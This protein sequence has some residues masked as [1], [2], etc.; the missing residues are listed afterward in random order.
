[1]PRSSLP[2]DFSPAEHLRKRQ[3]LERVDQVSFSKSDLNRLV[4]DYLVT[5]GY[6]SAAANLALEAEI[7][8]DAIDGWSFPGSVDTVRA[9][10]DIRNALLMGQVGKAISIINDVDSM[11]LDKC[12]SLHFAVLQLQFIELIRPLSSPTSDISAALRFATHNLAPLAPTNS[13]FLSQLEQTMCLLIFPRDKL[14]PDLLKLLD[15]SLRETVAKRVNRALLLSPALDDVD[16]QDQ[17]EDGSVDG[18]DETWRQFCK[19]TSLVKLRH[20]VEKELRRSQATGR[21]AQESP[22]TGASS[23][24]NGITASARHNG[25]SN[26]TTRTGTGSTNNDTRPNVAATGDSSMP[27][28]R[29]SQHHDDYIIPREDE[30][31]YWP[32]GNGSSYLEGRL[33]TGDSLNALLGELLGDNIAFNNNGTPNSASV[34]DGAI[35]AV[36]TSTDLS[37]EQRGQTFQQQQ[38]SQQLL[39]SP[40]VQVH[41]RDVGVSPAPEESRV[42][43]SQ[44]LG[45]ELHMEHPVPAPEMDL[46]PEYVP[47]LRQL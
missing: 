4:M 22:L 36:A 31:G 40:D 21:E 24:L 7:D 30:L 47:L 44:R 16:E 12:S 14:T 32:G 42:S 13:K 17:C 38:H 41:V 34:G 29:P 43:E 3:Y 28:T 20:C 9:R 11:L 18:G 35:Y 33:A 1:M 23:G 10:A 26:G 5:A 25:L 2:G 8:A 39:S 45:R 46:D 6:P 27:R 15:P 19:M 37:N